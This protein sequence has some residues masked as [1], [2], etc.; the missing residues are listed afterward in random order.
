MNWEGL[1]RR[2]VYPLSL[3]AIVLPWV[4]VMY[5]KKGMI[6]IGGTIAIALAIALVHLKQEKNWFYL[7]S[8][9]LPFSI[10]REIIGGVN[11]MF[12]GEAMI[13]IAA[14]M[15]AYRI[16]FCDVSKAKFSGMG[17]LALSL[18]VWLSISTLFSVNITY[19]LKY[20]LVAVAYILV[21]FFYT[22]QL[23]NEGVKWEKMMILSTVSLALISAFSI[24]NFASLGFG[25][26]YSN[27]IAR[28]FFKDHTIM[29]AALG[30][31]IPFSFYKCIS[32]MKTSSWGSSTIFALITIVLSANLWMGHSRAAWLSVIL[33]FGLLTVLLIRV[34]PRLIVLG[35]GVLMAILL[36]NWG[37]LV[38][39]VS[40]NAAD[41]G[42]MQTNVWEETQSVTNVRSDVSNLERIN[43]WK[44]AWRMQQDKPWTGFGPGTYQYAY[45]PY[46]DERDMTRISIRNPYWVKDIHGGTAHSEPILLLA[47]TGWPGA[48]IWGLMTIGIGLLFGHRLQ[49]GKRWNME[50]EDVICVGLAGFF[51]HALVNNFLHTDKIAFL[52]WGSFAL[53]SYSF[54][55]ERRRNAY[56]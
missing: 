32:S 25:V 34:Q 39:A 48:V 55:K 33:S 18:V 15:Y 11:L 17:K 52:F 35:A 8:F 29:G 56:S 40:I 20:T 49:I 13:A 23:L 19:S 12:P 10:E 28:P 6:A 50:I 26:Q 43:R 9:V 37:S 41:S 42:K 54:N 3:L 24:Y 5:P 27:L 44:S 16:L 51:L 7:M 2:I 31:V 47:E 4:L 38:D 22:K 30:F 53:L 46:Q 1:D 36:L 21:F 45:I 14:I